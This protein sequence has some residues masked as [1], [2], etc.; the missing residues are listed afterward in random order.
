MMKPLSISMMPQLFARFQ[1]YFPQRELRAIW[2]GVEPRAY[3]IAIS[4]Q[5]LLQ[6]FMLAFLARLTGLREV[7]RRCG[8]LLGTSCFSSLADALVRAR[9]VEFACRALER[10]ECPIEPPEAQLVA[11]D[12]MAQTLAATQR[13][14]CAKLNDKSVGGGVL[15]AFWIGAHAPL[16]PVR[17][18]KVVAGAWCDSRL[19]RTV[20]LAANGPIYLMDRGF[21][22]FD[23]LRSWMSGQVR[24]IVRARERCLV[25]A[26]EKII[27]AASARYGSKTLLLDA[28]VS[29]GAPSAK[30]HPRVRLLRFRLPSGETLSLAT[31]LDERWSAGCIL[32]YY[33]ER[34]KI[35][36]LHRLI[37]ETLG[38]AHLYSFHWRGIVF[39][40][41]TALILALLLFL[42]DPGADAVAS[43]RRALRRARA[44]LG[45]SAPWR[46]N[47]LPAQQ[48]PKKQEKKQRI[49]GWKPSYA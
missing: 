30:S 6:A 35:E 27:T 2:A 12:S 29:L 7:T 18:L 11:L 22:A 34:R 41:Y 13:H 45:L 28:W 43:M 10:L 17:V 48:R 21:Y 5:G 33:R 23:L 9:L 31:S 46:R 16:S 47:L 42:S 14:H 1:R 19:M 24:F 3:P 37:K 15:W 38:L 8:R 36:P 4:S 49:K 32:L 40:L 26:V 44:C 20:T 39:L 25:F